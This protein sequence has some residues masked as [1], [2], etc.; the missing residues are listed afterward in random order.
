M[1]PFL[2]QKIIKNL[3]L[4]RCIGLEVVDHPNRLTDILLVK[5]YSKLFLEKI[6]WMGFIHKYRTLCMLLVYIIMLYVLYLF[7]SLNE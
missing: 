4:E 3:S 2:T 1:R 7:F 6:R 5:L